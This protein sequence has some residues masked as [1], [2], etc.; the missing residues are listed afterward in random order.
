MLVK[1]MRTPT[2]EEGARLQ[3]QLQ[4]MLHTANMSDLENTPSHVS[5]QMLSHADRDL[6]EEA[7]ESLLR[8][9]SKVV[10]SR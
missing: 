6:L 8:L 5:R 3:M 1:R 2:R 4:R 9:Y 10:H 7:S